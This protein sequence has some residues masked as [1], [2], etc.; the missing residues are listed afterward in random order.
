MHDVCQA[1]FANG[2][3][4][5]S[6]LSLITGQSV[7]QG[8]WWQGVASTLASD[9]AAAVS[10]RQGTAAQAEAD[11]E[12]LL[13]LVA[14]TSFAHVQAVL[15]TA[16]GTPRLAHLQLASRCG[17]HQNLPQMLQQNAHE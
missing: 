16:A 9:A 13:M 10:A 15:V 4:L 11:Q 1:V 3:C 14:S 8:C 17:A 7:M 5:L 12:A 6:S 2:Q